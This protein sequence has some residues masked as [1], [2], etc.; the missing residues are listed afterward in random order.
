MQKAEDVFKQKAKTEKEKTG[1][2]SSMVSSTGG[3]ISFS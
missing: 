1:S 3:K 2:R